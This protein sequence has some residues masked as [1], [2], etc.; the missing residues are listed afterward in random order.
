M[1]DQRFRARQI[2]L[3]I[4]R[5]GAGLDELGFRLN[6]G[7]ALGK[8]QR[9]RGSQIGWQRFKL[10]CHAATESY[11]SATAKQKPSSHDVGRHVSC[12]YLQSMPDN[13]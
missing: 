2:R 6:A 5:L 10:R 7:G 11:S 4:G 12:G 13:R 8:D 9:M 1:A 3:R